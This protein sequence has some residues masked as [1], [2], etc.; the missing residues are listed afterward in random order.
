VGNRKARRRICG[1]KKQKNVQSAVHT[2]DF[3]IAVS[4]NIKNET[5]KEKQ[6]QKRE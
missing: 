4:N 3:F 5:N 6:S 1:R 2:A